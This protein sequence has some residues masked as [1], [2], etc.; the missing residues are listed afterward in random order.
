MK[1]FNH[2]FTLLELL[3]II[4]ILGILS[5][6]AIPYYEKYIIKARLV[7]VEHAMAVVKSAVSEYHQEKGDSW[8]NCP[9][10]NEI[11]S[12][13]G[14]GLGAVSRISLL[15]ITSAT[16]VITATVD[17]VHTTVNGKTIS[18]TPTSNAD[19]SISWEWGW[20]TDF[21]EQLKDKSKKEK[22]KGKDKK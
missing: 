2:G 17:N 15:S 8:P 18:L 20:S 4:A 7:E 12:S 13:L 9:S 3:I 10:L 5:A 19:G 11:R 1:N 14:V 22:G 6:I 21:P 16:G